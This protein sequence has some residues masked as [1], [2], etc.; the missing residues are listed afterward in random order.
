MARVLRGD[1]V[2]A[3]LDPVRGHEHHQHAPALGGVEVARRG[4]VPEEPLHD[5]PDN[6]PRLRLFGVHAALAPFRQTVADQFGGRFLVALLHPAEQL[7]G[8]V[9]G[10]GNNSGSAARTPSYWQALRG[11]RKNFGPVV[12]SACKRQR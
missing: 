4:V 10:H 7:N 12:R 11:A 3:E 8:A 6:R 5:L 2:W 1:I 9:F